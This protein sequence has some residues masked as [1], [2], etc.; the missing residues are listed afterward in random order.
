[1]QHGVN[2]PAP[3]PAPTSPLA[4]AD[5]RKFWL[6]RFCTTLASTGMV[7]IIGYQLY[8]IARDE[9]GMTI[10]QA[11][12][13]LGLLGFAQFIPVFFL[14]PVAGVLADRMDRRKLAGS[15]A[16]LDCLVAIGLAVITALH[17]RNLPVLYGFAVLHGVVRVFIRPAMGAIAPNIVPPQL[18]PKAI[19]LNSMAMQIGVIVGPAAAGYLFAWDRPLPYSVSALAQIISAVGIL[20]IRTLPPMAEDARKVHP[21]RQLIEGFHFIWHERFLLGSITLDLFAVLLGGATALMPV[22]ARDILHVGPEGLGAMRAATAVG[23]T[24]VALM[25]SWRPLS[26]EVGVKMLLSVAL[27][28]AATL[29]FGLSRN[30]AFS[31]GAL[32]VLGAADMISMFV[33][34][35]LVQL[36]TPDDKRGR[37]SAISGLA[38]SASNEL[39][40]MQSGVAAAFLGA[41]G[42]VVFGG[43]G[44]ILITAVWA[45][46]FPE[47]RRARTFETQETTREVSTS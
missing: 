15:A 25:L 21:V 38:I 17:F 36:R 22:F 8:D 3:S 13:Q 5:Y 32:A 23:A 35:S 31:L 9:Y 24:V 44:A 6:A 1:M 19:A 42:A 34:G 26:K 37:V 4:I 11:S 45:V 16:V 40:E 7:V 30:F 39:G 18:I 14:T 10:A 20:A 12:F 28:G 47:I 33:R 2:T 46:L 29:A 41:T 27:Y 43:A